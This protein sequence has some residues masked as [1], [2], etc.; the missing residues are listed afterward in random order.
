MWELQS[1]YY[2]RYPGLHSHYAFLRFHLLVHWDNV[3]QR[4]PF[5]KT[6]ISIYIIGIG[7]MCNF[8]SP[9][10]FSGSI[11]NFLILLKTWFFY[12]N[13]PINKQELIILFIILQMLSKRWLTKLLISCKILSKWYIWRKRQNKEKI[14]FSKW[15]SESRTHEKLSLKLSLNIMSET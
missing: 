1:I 11:G 2:P 12:V 10:R 3:M 13:S 15:T 8:G 14:W 9:L 5:V 6:N 4:G 7:V